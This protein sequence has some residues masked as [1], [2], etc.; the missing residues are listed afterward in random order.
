MRTRIPPTYRSGVV[1]VTASYEGDKDAKEIGFSVVVYSGDSVQVT[2]DESISPPPYS[3][4]VRARS[5]LSSFDDLDL[6]LQVEGV[7]TNKNSGGNST[8]PTF[9]V[10]PQYHLRIYPPTKSSSAGGAARK[11]KTKVLLRA[12]KDAPVNTVVVWSKGDRKAE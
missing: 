11:S 7:L 5:F 4:K 8:Y 1:V 6:L 12:G 10:N 2:W 9:M 3:T